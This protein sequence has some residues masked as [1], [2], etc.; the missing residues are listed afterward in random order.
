MRQ[1]YN[2]K[3]TINIPF[4]GKCEN[5]STLHLASSSSFQNKSNKIHQSQLLWEVF[6]RQLHSF[7]DA[8]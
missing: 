7:A 4:H 1:K 5:T 3:K 8:I 6:L 2:K